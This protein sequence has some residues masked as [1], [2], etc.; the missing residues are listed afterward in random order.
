MLAR[1]RRA[2]EILLKEA[3]AKRAAAAAAEAAAKGSPT[4]GVGSP[5]LRWWGFFTSGYMLGIIIV[6]VLVH[7]I[8]NVVVPSRVQPVHRRRNQGIVQ[9]MY[10]SILPIDLDKATTRL[11]LHSVSLYL[12]LR[13]LVVWG[14]VVL[15]TSQLYPED[16]R[17]AWLQRLGGY[18]ERLPMGRICWDTFVA[19]CAVTCAQAFTRGLDGLGNT[20]LTSHGPSSPNNLVCDAYH[21]HRHRLT[22]L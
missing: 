18:V 9:R 13:M 5:S 6:A 19:I 22:T 11:A 3:M 4:A 14:V 21:I 17:T 12:I 2:D 15:Q 16:P 10:N 8:Q 7:R 1:M 20:L